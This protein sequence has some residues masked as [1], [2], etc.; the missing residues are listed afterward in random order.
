MG[1]Y[2]KSSKWLIEHHGDAMLRLAGI[3]GIVSWKPLPAEVV[4]PG[5]LPDGILDVLL[6]GES[7]PAPFVIEIAT[8]PERRVEEQLTRDA[9]L[10]CLNRRELPEVITLV[11]RPKGRLRVPEVIS[12]RSRGGGTGL[13]LRCRVV[14]LWT[15]PAEQL[16]ATDDPGFMPWVPLCRHGGRPET[17]L[18]RCRETTDQRAAEE[19]RDSLLAVTQVLA[20]LRYHDRGLLSIL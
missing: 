2:D 8:F 9:M 15:V 12:L 19:E 11:L 10:V 6:A 16:L 3:A 20:G 14:D 1:V 7:E 13:E 5:Q 18:R 17:V 4:Q